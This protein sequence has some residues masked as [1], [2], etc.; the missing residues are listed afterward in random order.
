MRL[1]ESDHNELLLSLIEMMRFGG[2]LVFPLIEK[3]G[4]RGGETPEI[5]ESLVNCGHEAAN[6]GKGLVRVRIGEKTDRIPVSWMTLMVL[7][8]V[9]DIKLHFVKGKSRRA[10]NPP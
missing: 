4:A 5:I 2:L 8:P 6:L 9:L 7:S 1:K 10:S 3:E